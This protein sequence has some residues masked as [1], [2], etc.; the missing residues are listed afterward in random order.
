MGASLKVDI[1]DNDSSS[2]TIKCMLETCARFIYTICNVDLT[3]IKES[4]RFFFYYIQYI[5]I[6]FST[7]PP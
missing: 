4:L 3:V 6:L 5:A 7:L 2:F 1:T